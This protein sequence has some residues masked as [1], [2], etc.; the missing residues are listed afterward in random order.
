MSVNVWHSIIPKSQKQ[1]KGSLAG[2]Q[3]NITVGRSE[4]KRNEV[5]G[6]S[7]KVLPLATTQVNFR[8]SLEESDV[9]GHVIGHATGHMTDHV[10]SHVT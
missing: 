2:E 4:I 9:T 10:T 7:G 5:L 3:I 8:N 6:F 1:H